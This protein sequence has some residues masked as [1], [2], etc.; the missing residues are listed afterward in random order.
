MIP[1]STSSL[2]ALQLQLTIGF[3]LPK[4]K[5]R[6]EPPKRQLLRSARLR[7]MPKKRLIE[8]NL[9]VST[10]LRKMLR[11]L[12]RPRKKL[13]QRSPLPQL[14]SIRTSSILRM[15]CTDAVKLVSNDAQMN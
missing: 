9:R 14:N 3:L 7:K 10:G 12:L 13:M 5:L 15:P 11:L 4:G 1:T 8:K 6:I 2:V